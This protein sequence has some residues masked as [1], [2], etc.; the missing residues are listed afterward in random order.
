[1]PKNKIGRK[2]LGTKPTRT[3]KSIF[4]QKM[5]FDAVNRIDFERYGFSRFDHPE[6]V[7]KNTWHIT[8]RRH[9]NA[10]GGIWIKRVE[11]QMFIHAEIF[12]GEGRRDDWCRRGKRMTDELIK[13]MV[14]VFKKQGFKVKVT[15]PV[16]G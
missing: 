4:E 6:K 11:D 12:G 7:D 1:M 3:W 9:G 10:F 15:P 14:K 13:P 5:M 2:V 8:L 16:F